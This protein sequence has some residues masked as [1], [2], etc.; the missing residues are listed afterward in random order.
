[1]NKESLIEK[2]DAIS[3]AFEEHR[4]EELR[5]QGEFRLINEFIEKLDCDGGNEE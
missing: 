2:R 1:M 3:K 4:S 5:L